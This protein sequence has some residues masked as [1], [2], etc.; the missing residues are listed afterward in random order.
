L[1]LQQANKKTNLML[2]KTL[3]NKCHRLKSFYIM[4]YLTSNPEFSVFTFN[5]FHRE[6]SNFDHS[7]RIKNMLV[8]IG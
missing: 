1:V 4:N 7:E 8:D 2:I 5:N 3:L 6:L